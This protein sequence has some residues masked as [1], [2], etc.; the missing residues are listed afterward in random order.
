[1]VVG[2]SL[3]SKTKTEQKSWGWVGFGGADPK[4][5]CENKPQRKLT[6]GKAENLVMR[7]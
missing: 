7:S 3:P 2:V 1:V 6:E 4:G 5:K